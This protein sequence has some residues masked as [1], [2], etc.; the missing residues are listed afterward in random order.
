MPSPPLVRLI[1]FFLCFFHLHLLLK[2]KDYSGQIHITASCMG[3]LQRRPSVLQTT[4][5]PP[6]RPHRAAS[7]Q[8]ASSSCCFAESARR[9]RVLHRG[10]RVAVALRWSTNKRW[11]LQC[12]SVAGAVRVLQWSPPCHAGAGCSET[13]SAASGAAME[14][15]WTTVGP[16]SA[17]L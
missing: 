3:G 4:N 8:S 16:M 15:R 5:H 7:Q 10:N 9:R 14:H 13:S 11:A 1:V 2:A 17:L 12:N 6:S